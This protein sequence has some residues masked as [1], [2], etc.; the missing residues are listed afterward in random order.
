MSAEQTYTS[1]D[2]Q[3]NAT[4]NNALCINDSSS[5]GLSLQRK[6]R[7]ANNTGLPDSLKSGV[8]SLSGYSLDDVRVH[9][10]SSKPAAVQ[11]YAYTQGTD[12]HIAPGQ[13]RCLPH[14]AWHV[15]QQMSG[16][17]SP[18]TSIGGVAVNDDASLE[19]EADVMG[20]RASTLQG[21]NYAPVSRKAWSGSSVRQNKSLTIQREGAGEGPSMDKAGCINAFMNKTYEKKDYKRLWY[22]RFDAR[23]TPKK[24]ELVV[25]LP[26]YYGAGMDAGKQ[27]FFEGNVHNTWS[28]QHHINFQKSRLE[29]SSQPSS[30]ISWKNNLVNTDVVVN[31]AKKDKADEAYFKLQTIPCGAS[32]V[33]PGGIVKL[34]EKSF[35]HINRLEDRE[36][37]VEN[38]DEYTVNSWNPTAH[39]AGHMLGLDDEYVY[40]G[41]HEG[42]RNEHYDLTEKALG[43]E[44]ADQHAIVSDNRP[45]TKENSIMDSG[46]KVEKHHY[47]TFWDAMVNA[48]QS[49]S[50]YGST[51]SL[52]APNQHEDWKIE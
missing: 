28:G 43:K 47:V 38:G 37:F 3:E 4:S 20:A 15:T 33:N 29:P 32:S 26:V 21:N 25:T 46:N 34:S 11:A 1:R 49:D 9:Y 22:G 10:N 31:V 13:E 40:E 27:T 2:N 36:T 52:K 23:Y 30:G 5:H 7:V 45:D 44:Y 17:V 48:I 19:H 50:E 18:T 14:E 24:H 51:P 8:E 41:M 42:E 16:R 6:A 12:I 35:K 39:E